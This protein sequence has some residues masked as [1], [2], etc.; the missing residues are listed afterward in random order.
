MMMNLLWCQLCP[1][2]EFFPVGVVNVKQ[3]HTVSYDKSDN[4]TRTFDLAKRNGKKLHY[5][6]SSL[7]PE[8]QY[9][10]NLEYIFSATMHTYLYMMMNNY[11]VGFIKYVSPIPKALVDMSR[12][13]VVLGYEWEKTTSAEAITWVARKYIHF[14]QT[15]A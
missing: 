1:K 3:F 12:D 6:S 14:L 10:Q 4:P 9:I 8:I 5:L 13:Q 7:N 11:L 15:F 2:T